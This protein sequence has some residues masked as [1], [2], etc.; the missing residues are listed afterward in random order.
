MLE[1]RKEEEEAEAAA[2][3]A[4]VAVPAAE[5]RRS[6][7]QAVGV[8]Q[9]GGSG[10]CNSC[11]GCRL[12][13]NLTYLIK[14]RTRQAAPPHSLSCS[15][16]PQKVLKSPPPPFTL[17]LPAT[18]CNCFLP[19][20]L[21][22]FV[23]QQR[24]PSLYLSPSY[25]HCLCLSYSI[26]SLCLSNCLP[27]LF[28]CLLSCHLPALFLYFLFSAITASGVECRGRVKRDRCCRC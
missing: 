14:S 9:A 20:T 16:T 12:L 21:Q 7:K 2:A 28:P 3:A 6:R 11:H 19:F 18:P 24:C 23:T 26:P 1:R 15:P 4:A 13:A 10:S 27:W 5:Q 17:P 25:T 22:L 8:R